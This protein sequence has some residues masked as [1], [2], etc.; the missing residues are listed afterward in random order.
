MN[1]DEH[2]LSVKLLDTRSGETYESMAYYVSQM[3]G[4]S[5][6]ALGTDIVP[7]ALKVNGEWKPLIDEK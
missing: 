5:P 6:I 7:I 3:G 2:I 1:G 4:F